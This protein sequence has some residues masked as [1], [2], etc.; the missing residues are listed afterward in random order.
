MEF[1]ANHARKLAEDATALD[2]EVAQAETQ[3]CLQAIKKAASS[4]LRSCDITVPYNHR[5]LITRRLEYAGFTIK[6][7][8]EGR[9]GDFT[10]ASW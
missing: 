6:T 1:T 5:T 7:T 2:G 9:D 10:T 4:G 3:V 8:S